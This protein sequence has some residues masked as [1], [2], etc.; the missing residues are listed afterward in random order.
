VAT[1]DQGRDGRAAAQGLNVL[2]A[3]ED[4]DALRST[5]TAL[6][7]LGHTVVSYAV[8]VRE[9][10]ARI[11]EDDPDLSVVAV[12]EDIDHALDLVEELVES[13]RGPVL[14]VA[15]GGNAG[16]F[17]PDAASRG[18]D[19]FAR[20]EDPDELQ[21]AIE[22]AVRR[23]T[24]AAELIAQVSQLESALERRAVI[25]RAKGI[26]M[27]RHAVGDRDAFALLRDHARNRGRKVVDVAHAVTE[28]H[29]LL[30]PAPTRE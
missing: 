8:S 7:G 24:Q 17:L 6:E 29:A 15:E 19:A 4:A 26:L 27:E 18:L 9:A 12:H 11:A 13:T 1:E 21:A 16:G 10:V 23:H 30:P 28:G 5:A 2:V 3:D 14:A 22:M 25:E 20:S